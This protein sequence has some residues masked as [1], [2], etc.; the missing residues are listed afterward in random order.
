MS[1]PIIGPIVELIDTGISAVAGHFKGKQEIKKAKIEGE[2]Q[3]IMQASQN[4]ADWEKIMAMNSG[5]SWK[6][7]YWTVIFSIPTIMA[8]IPGMVVYVND[9]FDALKAMPEWYIYTLVTMV[10]ASFGIRMKDGIKNM[11]G[12]FIKK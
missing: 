2:K 3:V 1:I 10:L 9:G 4:I 6:D 7:E 5:R 8:F 11:V 12:R